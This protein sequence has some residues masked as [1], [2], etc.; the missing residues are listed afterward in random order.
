MTDPT[1]PAATLLSPTPPPSLSRGGRTAL[2][3]GV[4]IAAVLLLLGGLGGLTAAAVGVGST[5][6]IADSQPLPA[7]MRSLTVNT[8]A[9]PMAVR[10]TADPDAREPRAEMRFISATRAGEHSLD[11][12][13]GTDTHI[14]VRGES[15]AWLEWAQAAEITVTLPPELGRRLTVTTTQ[16]LGVLEVD[17]DLDQLVARTTTGTVVLGSAI[18]SVDIDV[19]NGTVLARDPF[20]VR[21][22]FSA[23]ILEGDITVDFRDVAPRTID[24][25][26]SDGDVVLGLPGTGPYLVNAS[27]DTFHNSTVIRVP[28]T[29]DPAAAKSVVTARSSSGDVV[30]EDVR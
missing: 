10:I 19:Q 23:N 5:R 22:S 14:S 7:T 29:T 20:L 18:G 25:T 6:V 27:A 13:S 11:I 4:V 17:A 9:L 2:R 16:Q 3:T 12:A 26:A 24:A 15:P 1:I 30:I 8:G 21:E 28:Q